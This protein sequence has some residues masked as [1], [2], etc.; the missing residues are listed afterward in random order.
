MIAKSL[1]IAQV[2]VPPYPGLG[3]AMGL[4][5]TDVKHGYVQSRLRHLD[6]DALPEMDSIFETLTARARAETEAEGTSFE[7]V[8]VERLAD[9]RYVGQGYE[10]PIPLGPGA[11]TGDTLREASRTFHDLHR[12]LYGNSAS[13]KPLEM[14]SLRLRTTAPLPKL[15]L[16]R[17]ERAGPSEAPIPGGSRLVYFEEA[18]GRVE[19]AIYHRGAL[20]AGHVVNGPAIVDQTDSTTVLLPRQ[21]A[22]VDEYANIIA[23]TGAKER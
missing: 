15:A 5:L 18:G 11:L 19:T 17:I 1:G 6:E 13:D 9:L 8:Q 4:L 23:E 2:I 20:K 12:E 14:I 16:P 21:R 3:S 7:A 10:L 22:R